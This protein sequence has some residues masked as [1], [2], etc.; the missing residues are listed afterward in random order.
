MSQKQPKLSKWRKAAKLFQS[1]SGAQQT[2][3]TGNPLV[4]FAW[5]LAKIIN[6]FQNQTLNPFCS[7]QHFED[8]QL[9]TFLRFKFLLALLEAKADM[10]LFPLQSLSR[11]CW[12]WENGL[13]E[14]SSIS[15]ILC[16]P[17]TPYNGI[18]PLNPC[19]SGDTEC[20]FKALK[21]VIYF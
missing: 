17:M 2:S 5:S 1:C 8:F 7:K 6:T 14:M 19:I 10:S 4:Q 15:S 13:A 20:S 11:V 16:R 12:C 18:T 3:G 21:A 9:V